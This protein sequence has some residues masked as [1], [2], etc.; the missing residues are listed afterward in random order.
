MVEG[1]YIYLRLLQHASV[2]MESRVVPSGKVYQQ[3]FDD[4]VRLTKSLLAARK[5]TAMMCVS[6]MNTPCSATSRYAHAHTHHNTNTHSCWLLSSTWQQPDDEDDGDGDE[7]VDDVTRLPDTVDGSHVTCDILQRVHQHKKKQHQEAVR[8]MDAQLTQLAQACVMQVRTHSLQLLSTLQRINV[9]VDA[10]QD[11]MQHVEQHSLQEVLCMW[12]EVEKQMKQKKRSVV[13]FQVQV[14]ECERQRVIKM[15]PVIRKYCHTLGKINFLPCADMHRQIHSEATMLNQTLLANRRSA[16]HVLLL[17]QESTLQ[18]EA[19]LHLQWEESLSRW[20]RS[21]AD[22]VVQEFRSA[23]TSGDVWRLLADQLTSQ[24]VSQSVRRLSQQRSDIIAEISSLVPPSFST[25]LVSDWFEQLTAVNQHIDCLHSDFLHQLRC[26]YELTWQERLAQVQGSKE[27]LSA[28]ELPEEEVSEMV[29]SELLSLVGQYQRQDEGQLATIETCADGLWAAAARLS[30]RAFLVMRALAL[31]WEEHS[32]NLTSLEEEVQRRLEEL[33]SAQE[34]HVQRKKVFLDEMLAG[35]RQESSEAA[36]KT[37]MEQTVH[38]LRNLRVS[39]GECVS[40]QCRV[41]DR[42]PH[43]FVDELDNYSKH[44]STFYHLNDTFTLNPQDLQKLP[45]VDDIITGATEETSPVSCPN[46]AEPEK[47]CDWL[48]ECVQAQSSLLDLYDISSKLAFTSSRG[49]AYSAPAFRCPASDLPG[50]MSK[51]QETHLSAFPVEMLTHSLSR[52]RTLFFEHLEQRYHDVLTSV[53][54][55]VMERKEAVQAYHD[56]QMQQLDPQHVR[57]CIY[58]PRLAELQQHKQRVDTHC[59]EVSD[60]LTSCRATL[61]QLQASVSKKNQQLTATLSKMDDNVLKTDGSRRLEAL[62]STL[63][64]CLDDHIKDTQR[65]HAGF[66]HMLQLQMEELRCKTA[67]LLHSFRLFSE[68]G[69]FTRHEVKIFQR[70]LREES[71]RISTAEENIYTDLQNLESKG[72]QQVKAGSGRFEEKLW[73]L[74]AEVKFMEKIQR[75]LSSTQVEVRAEGAS[76]NHQEA[77]IS[78]RLEEL[79]KALAGEQ[80]CAEQVCVLLSFISDA[81]RRRSHYLDEIIPAPATSK[82]RKQVWSAPPPA[83][84]Q[85]CRSGGN[86]LEDPIVGVVKSLNRFCGGH[87]PAAAAGPV[88]FKGRSPAHRQPSSRRSESAAA[89]RS[90]R[91]DKRFQIFGSKPEADQNPDCYIAIVNAVLRRTH[92]TLLLVAKDFYQSQ[93]CGGFHLLPGALDQWVDGIQQRLL[94]YQQHAKTLL[95]AS[96]EALEQQQRVLADTMHALPDKLIRNHEQRMGAELREEADLVRQ[97]FE[98]TLA[99]SEKEK[100]ANVARLRL[101]LSHSELDKLSRSEDDRQQRLHDDIRSSHQQLQECARCKGEEFVTSL[102]SLTEKLLLQMDQLP[103]AEVTWEDRPVTMETGQQP[104]RMWSGIPHLSADSTTTASIT[105][106]RCTVGHVAV[107]EH[108]DA[109]VKRPMSEDILNE[110]GEPQSPSQAPS[111]LSPSQAPSKSQP[112]SSSSSGPSSGSQ[113]SGTLSSVDTLPVT[114]PS[115]PEEPECQPWG[116]LLPMDAGFRAHD[117]IEDEYLFGRDSK[118]HYVLDDPQQRGS[119][120]YRIYSKKHF[121]IYRVPLPLPRLTHFFFACVCARASVC[122]YKCA[123]VCARASQEGSEAFIHDLSNNGTFV[124]GIKIGRNKKLPLVN[125]AV[126]ALSEQ[127]N[128]VFVFIDLMSDEDG[129]LPGPLRDKYLLTR[130]IGTGVCGEVRLAFERSTCKKFAVKIIN[131]KNFQSEGT[132]TRNAQTEIEILQRIDHPCLI[133]TQD[134]Y[135]TD[136]SFFIVLELMEGGELFQRVKVGQLSESVAKLYFY[137]MLQAVQYLHR[138][139]IIHRD[140]KPEN[141]LLSSHE[142]RCLIKVTDFNQSRILEEAVLMRTLCGTPSYLA[143]EVFTHAATTGYS[144]AVDAWSLGVLLFV[145]LG[146]YPPF[147]ENFGQLSVTD[148]IIR[149]EFTMVPSKWTHVSDQGDLPLHQAACEGQIWNRVCVCVCVCVCVRACVRACACVPAKDVVRKLL[150]VDPTKRMSIQEALQHA[151]L[152]DPDMLKE[153]QALMHPAAA[154][155]ATEAEPGSSRKRR[156]EDDECEHPAKHAPPAVLP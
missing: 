149:G 53:V 78:A 52:A 136:D 83:L 31:L 104:C 122:V 81:L 49:V 79:R 51:Q 68:G 100:R 143:P 54:A 150:V 74:Q 139:G 73:L 105:T 114:L 126:L 50:N 48:A 111:T 18:Q 80:V 90:L 85:P 39:C 82:S 107:I 5:H 38:Y 117:C 75:I 88:T 97:K 14:S 30:R 89:T 62:S 21:R 109:A 22:Q 27:A 58:M 24:E 42:L 44:L 113:S 2:S 101:S 47:P 37:S 144:L 128:K 137:Q 127:R 36:L 110:G 32:G 40:D 17:L 121:R 59:Q 99:A 138:N 26:C 67:S 1:K 76:S 123:C 91:T 112:G 28:L 132:A 125:N 13:D 4:Q 35:L 96:R 135:Q 95:S 56:L 103:L 146:G 55:T 43:D 152:Q 130:R 69:D 151:W 63:Q 33:R 106:S 34:K 12:S 57:V 116:R 142:D 86:I 133:K 156:R 71:K 8:H 45:P 92:H 11:N 10:V 134:F 140:L 70:R 9:C 7:D 29:K 77:T 25:A 66:R 64:N 6:A 155:V 153:A 16:A 84:L 141:I 120:R 61:H 60:V 65:S 115:V 129:A 119:L 131:K 20:R 15:R 46:V 23:L 145:C 108:R 94:G 87:D 154:A 102:A 98:K 41:L 124:D 147:H 93:R 148:Q 118:C 3:L 19:L 72:L